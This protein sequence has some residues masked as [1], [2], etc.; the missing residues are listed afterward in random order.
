MPAPVLGHIGF[1]IVPRK[2]GAG[3][4]ALALAS[5]LR[6]ITLPYV[7]LTADLDNVESQKTLSACNGRPLERFYKFPLTAGREGPLRFSTEL[8]ADWPRRTTP[9]PFQPI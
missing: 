9:R 7:D 3:Y 4:A 8:P 6:D 2:R 1:S 5:L